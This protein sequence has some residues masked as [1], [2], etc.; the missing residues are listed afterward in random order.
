MP[1]LAQLG[2][3]HLSLAEVGF[4][5]REL[6]L[7]FCFCPFV[8]ASLALP[9]LRF[10]CTSLY[11]CCLFVFIF[12]FSCCL[13][14]FCVLL[15]SVLFSPC[16]PFGVIVCPSHRQGISQVLSVLFDTG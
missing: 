8:C 7:V 10:P 14:V 6:T 4:N 5:F 15:P 2:G 16:S 11:L 9:L 1:S 3:E 13:F 12:L